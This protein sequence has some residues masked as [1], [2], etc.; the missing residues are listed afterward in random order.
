[1]THLT[2]LP[3]TI[4]LNCIESLLTAMEMK[5]YTNH[6]CNV[7]YTYTGAKSAKPPAPP[8]PVIYPVSPAAVQKEKSVV[9]I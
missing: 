6:V 4:Y 1:M 5:P 2:P 8:S 9:L 7:N 3:H